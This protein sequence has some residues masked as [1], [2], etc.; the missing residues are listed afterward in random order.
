MTGCSLHA[1]MKSH[2]QSVSLRDSKST[3]SKCIVE[4]HDGESMGFTMKPMTGHMTVLGRYKG[5]AVFIEQQQEG[6]SING[7]ME[8]GRG[9]LV[10]LTGNINRC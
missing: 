3:L 4:K 5:E 2:M 8:G 9:G 1:R 7:R 6:T 10:R